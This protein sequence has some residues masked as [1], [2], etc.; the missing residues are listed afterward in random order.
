[1]K[2]ILLQNV[3]SLGRKFDIVQV[4]DGYALNFLFPKQL[5]KIA[6]D[7]AVQEI[8]IRKK[9]ELIKGE[10][11]KAFEK[12]IAEKI[13]E[14]STITLQRKTSTK[15]HLFAAVGEKDILEALKISI[16]VELE[17]HHIFMT[18]HIKTLGQ[19][20]VHIVVG[21]HK[22]PLTIVI[23]KSDDKK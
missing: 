21:E 7:H 6:N 19:H 1:M 13:K 17:A 8:A 12:E 16:H 11:A 22:I 10:E 9:K 20:T 3:P 15:D 2:V 23:E 14:L 4:K 18:E 5:A